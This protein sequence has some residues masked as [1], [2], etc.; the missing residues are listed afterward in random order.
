MSEL[1]VGGKSKIDIKPET[2]GAISVKKEAS[3][4][5]IH[6][7]ETPILLAHFPQEM[8]KK[9]LML[10]REEKYNSHV[11]ILRKGQVGRDMFLICQGRISVWK[12]NI[13]LGELLKGDVF[14]ELV[15]FRDH[16][17]IATVRTE[18]PTIVLRYNRQ[19]LL[20]FFAR[21]DPRYFNI[22]TMNIIE[23]LRRKLIATNSRVVKL[24]EELVRQ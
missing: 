12:E 23:I 19:C 18:E 9:F 21:Q 14:G 13:I 7:K 6:F 20:D 3:G 15:M 8:A 1:N 10:G 24:E 11:D 5:L 22:Y 2:G 4:T 17:R 16:Y